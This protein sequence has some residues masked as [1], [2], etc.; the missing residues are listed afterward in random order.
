MYNSINKNFLKLKNIQHY[1]RFTDVGPS[2]AE[3]MIQT[4]RN[5]LKKPVFEKTNADWLSELLSVIKKNNKIHNSIKT[6]PVQTSKKVNEK[7]VYSNLK[8]NTEIQKPKYKLGEIVG[9]ADIIKVFSKRDSA[10]Y[11]YNLSTIT[12]V[13]LD[14]IHR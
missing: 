3:R 13:I 5:L 7:E 4:L 14:T 11:G 8:D 1:S 9:T 12:E 2:I 10:N 6:T